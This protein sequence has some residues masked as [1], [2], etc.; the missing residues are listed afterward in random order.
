MSN[1]TN[2]RIIRWVLRIVATALAILIPWYLFRSIQ[3]SAS[4]SVFSLIGVI[5]YI[6]YFIVIAGLITFWFNEVWAGIIILIGLFLILIV[7][8]LSLGRI[9]L[10]WYYFSVVI[11]AVVFILFGNWSKKTLKNVVFKNY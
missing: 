4:M 9:H 1:Q 3:I 7:G 11:L 8:A 5:S 6:I 10:D 2:V